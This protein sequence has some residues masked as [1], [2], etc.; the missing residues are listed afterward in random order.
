MRTGW[1]L[2]GVT[3]A[4]ATVALVLQ[5]TPAAPPVSKLA[6]VAVHDGPA[7]PADVLDVGDV[8]MENGAMPRDAIHAGLADD[9]EACAADGDDPHAAGD[10]G[11]AAHGAAARAVE[12]GALAA[13]TGEGAT[14]VSE[15]IARAGSLA[16]RRVR[17][18]V[19][20][21]RSTPAVLGRNWLH[22]QDGTGSP[23][24]AD[25]DLVV[26]TEQTAQVGDRVVIEGVVATDKDIGSG[27]RY[28][29]LVEDAELAPA[30]G[31]QP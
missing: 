23:E 26:T 25:F 29:V 17:L 11:E 3:V 2:I 15:L 18:A 30:A 24:R 21:V 4:A 12:P 8:G 31:A 20:I 13:A 5:S 28:A 6:A 9:G 16:G 14:T 27:Y 19:Q 10:T 1:I 7:A 22:V